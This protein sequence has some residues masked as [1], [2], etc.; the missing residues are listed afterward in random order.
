ML[1]MCLNASSAAC[2]KSNRRNA[3][4]TPFSCCPWPTQAHLVEDVVVALGVVHRHHT[5]PLQQVGAD[6][7]ACRQS[8]MHMSHKHQQGCA[9]APMAAASYLQDKRTLQRP[10]AH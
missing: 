3:P 7:G 2:S 4:P 8:T 5:R 1:A 9:A 6:C 10:D